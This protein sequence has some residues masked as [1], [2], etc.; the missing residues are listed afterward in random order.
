MKFGRASRVSRLI[1]NLLDRD[2]E[3]LD[4]AKERL[5]ELGQQAVPALIAALADP[6]F[7]HRHDDVHALQ[8]SPMEAVLNLLAEAAPE[9]A[10]GPMAAL[11]AHPSKDIRKNAALSLGETG[12]ESALDLVPKALADSDANVR[13]YAVMGIERGAHREHATAEFRRRAFELLVPFMD[14]TEI[15]GAST[16]TPRALISIDPIRGR[17]VLLAEKYFDAQYESIWEVVR[18]LNNHGAEIPADRIEVLAAELKSTPATRC[19]IGFAYGEVLMAMARTGH[20]SAPVRIRDAIETG[21]E[22]LRD[23]AI[24]AL[25]QSRWPGAKELLT[26][27][28]CSE[29]LTIRIEAGRALRKLADDSTTTQLS[30]QDRVVEY[31]FNERFL[32]DDTV[33]TE[34]GRFTIAEHD[35]QAVVYSFNSGSRRFYAVTAPFLNAFPEWG[36]SPREACCVHVGLS[37]EPSECGAERTKKLAPRLTKL[38][39]AVGLDSSTSAVLGVWEIRFGGWFERPRVMAVVRSSVDEKI[40]VVIE[41]LGAAT[42]EERFDAGEPVPAFVYVRLFLGQPALDEV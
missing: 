19:S 37:L 33:L 20:P 30:L 4:S 22:D 25:A 17:E 21:D 24:E 27:L 1:S 6:R 29:K 3:V 42:F 39:D 36:L 34:A 40:K 12:L 10:I 38:L 14:D 8:D 11:L 9:A 23:N 13:S 5:R 28:S 15:W 31:L 41:R 7:N 32:S 35:A 16:Y 26:E 2:G 18:E